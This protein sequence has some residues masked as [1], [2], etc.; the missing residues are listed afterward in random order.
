MARSPHEKMLNIANNQRIA[1]QNH[2][3]PF[4]PVRMATTKKQKHKCWRG[5]GGAGTLALLVSM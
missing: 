2:K 5:C 4:T 1:K 3:V